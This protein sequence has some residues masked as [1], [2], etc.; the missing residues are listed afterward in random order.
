[1]FTGSQASPF[2][3][4]QWQMFFR[5][6]KV[7][8]VWRSNMNEIPFVYLPDP[9]V[10]LRFNLWLHTILWYECGQRLQLEKG[11][12]IFRWDTKWKYTHSTISG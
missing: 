8:N 10:D 12:H 2:L 7:A 4:T 3:A 5:S 11:Q 6:D 9:A 1:M